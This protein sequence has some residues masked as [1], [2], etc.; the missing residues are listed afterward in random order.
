MPEPRAR[1]G[2]IVFNCDDFSKMERFWRG[3]LGYVPRDPP[4]PDAGQFIVL[5]DPTGQGPNL[6]IDRGEPER[7][8]IHLDLYST[9][10]EGDVQRILNL[11]GK[12]YR[13]RR[14]GEDFTVLEDPEG[15][16]FCVVDKRS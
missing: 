1:I 7:G 2:S 3:A 9:D 15:N 10:P 12:L 4:D 11:G 14:P 16:L 6:S 8:R 5:K 13:E